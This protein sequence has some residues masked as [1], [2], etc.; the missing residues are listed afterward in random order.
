MKYYKILRH[1]FKTLQNQKKLLASS[2][3]QKEEE[4]LAVDLKKKF[5][6]TIVE[7][8]VFM[9]GV[10]QILET[11]LK[12]NEKIQKQAWKATIKELE[13]A[14]FLIANYEEYQSGKLQYAQFRDFYRHYFDIKNQPPRKETKTLFPER[15]RKKT[16]DTDKSRKK[17]QFSQ[18]TS[19]IEESSDQLS[20]QNE[21]SSNQQDEFSTVSQEFEQTQMQDI[22]QQ[23]SDEEENK[24]NLQNSQER[25]VRK[26]ILHEFT[27][28][29]N[30]SKNKR[31]QDK[32]CK[33]RFKNM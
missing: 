6:K 20:S 18:A 33:I 11:C 4:F 10:E 9:N 2:I 30:R 23:H 3:A 16:G 19:S 29:N 22:T 12:L 25:E 26:T 8:V 17:S 7:I 14:H 15:Q 28:N 24:E 27:N 32:K 13:F 31:N 5:N 1:L 21:S